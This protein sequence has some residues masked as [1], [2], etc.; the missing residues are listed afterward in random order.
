MA[1]LSHSPSYDECI[2]NDNI[3]V[4]SSL[5][6]NHNT[7]TLDNNIKTVEKPANT[8]DTNLGMSL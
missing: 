6:L 5:V 1:F 7:T 3:D 8:I 2:R 4:V